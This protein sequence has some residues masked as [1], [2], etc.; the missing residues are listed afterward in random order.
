M[1]AHE[2]MES[3]SSARQ[4]GGVYWI[5]AGDHDLDQTAQ[6]SRYADESQLVELIA[7]G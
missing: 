4:G 3:V 5:A 1:Q 6:S 7:C 2:W